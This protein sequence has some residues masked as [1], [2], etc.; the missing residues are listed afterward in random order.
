MFYAVLNSISATSRRFL[1]NIPDL[2]VVFIYPDP[3]SFVVMVS[4]QTWVRWRGVITTTLKCLVWPIGQ[5][6]W[7]SELS[8]WYNWNNVERGVTPQSINQYG[9]S[10]IEHWSPAHNTDDLTRTQRWRSPYYM[11]RVY[12]W[13]REYTQI[14]NIY[15]PFNEKNNIMDSA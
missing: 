5:G 13:L 4:T 3:E 1:G 14:Q 2:L 11:N 12:K 6:S 9:P 7:I 15:Q 10:E 8:Q